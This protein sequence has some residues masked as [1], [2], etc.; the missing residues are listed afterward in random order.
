MRGFFVLGKVKEVCEVIYAKNN[1]FPIHTLSDS[2]MAKCTLGWSLGKLPSFIPL[3]Y[4]T[5]S[6]LP[7]FS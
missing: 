5:H 6:L 4:S 1:V 2:V 3:R 7:Q